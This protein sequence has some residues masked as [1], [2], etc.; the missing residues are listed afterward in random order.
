MIVAFHF[1]S[2]ADAHSL[3]ASAVLLDSP[4]FGAHSMSYYSSCTRWS[5]IFS[6]TVKQN[7]AKTFF[8][9]AMILMPICL[10]SGCGASVKPVPSGTATGTIKVNGNALKQGRVN[11]VS[12]TTGTGS[13][14][15]LQEDGSYK[16]PSAIPVGNYRVYLTIPDLG[17]APPSESGN[18]ELNNGLKGVPKKY[19]SEQMTDLQ[20][21]VKE[22]ENSF[23]FDLKP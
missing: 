8:L 3:N 5:M 21:V 6:L 17:D 15:D 2:T 7:I 19:Q 22:G 14:A 12:S 10:M 23:D 20:A 1:R 11:F 9:S 18:P 4:T 13:Y 16:I